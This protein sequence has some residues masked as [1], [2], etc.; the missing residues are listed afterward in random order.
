MCWHCN[1]VWWH[2]NAIIILINHG[3]VHTTFDSCIVFHHAYLVHNR[4]VIGSIV[5]RNSKSYE[6]KLIWKLSICKYHRVKMRSL[7]WILVQYNQRLCK[8]SMPYLGRHRR[9]LWDTGDHGWRDATVIKTQVS[10]LRDWKRWGRRLPGV[11]EVTDLQQYLTSDSNFQNQKRITFQKII[12]MSSDLIIHVFPPLPSCKIAHNGDSID[13]SD[14]AP[15]P[16]QIPKRRYC[17]LT[18]TIILHLC[19]IWY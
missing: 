3:R 4:L 8:R 15:G 9:L 18:F 19:N 1:E 5:C 6:C 14:P 13:S 16:I 10:Y 2:V 12:H 11:S 7:G 17:T